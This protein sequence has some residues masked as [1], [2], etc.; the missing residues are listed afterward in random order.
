MSWPKKEEMEE[1]IEIGKCRFQRN[2]V[3]KN[4]QAQIQ[5]KIKN[6]SV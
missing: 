1:I 5:Q 6:I 2:V 3:Y 4:I